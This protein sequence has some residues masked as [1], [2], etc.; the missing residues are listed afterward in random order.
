[1]RNTTPIQIRFSDLDLAG[2]VNN[3][4]YLTYFE[5]GRLDMQRHFIPKDHDWFRSG[6]ILA[7]NEVDYR[8]PIL[9]TDKVQVQTWCSRV[10][11]K[12]FDLRGV[13]AGADDGRI[14][15]ECRSVLVCFDYAK[16]VSIPIPGEWRNTLAR[17][18]ESDKP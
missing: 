8:I 7:R 10:G 1:M 16:Q 6:F 9:L 12:S 11:G 2:H 5:L 17:I 18:M 13:V 14:F 15:A 4:I 3:A